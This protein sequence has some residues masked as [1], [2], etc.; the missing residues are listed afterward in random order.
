VIQKKY[1]DSCRSVFNC[2][3]FV[4]SGFRLEVAEKCALLWL[5]TQPVVVKFMTDV[6]GP[7]ADPILRVQEYKNQNDS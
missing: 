7:P 6:S 2:V 5:I 4:I 3:Q 1:R